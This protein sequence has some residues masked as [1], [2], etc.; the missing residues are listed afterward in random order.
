[1][2][3][4]FTLL[5]SLW[6]LSGSALA[7]FGDG[8]GILTFLFVVLG[9]L[10]ALVLHEFG[11]AYVAWRA[12]DHTVET[13]GYLSMDPLRYAD[14]VTSLVLPVI[15]LAIGGL[16]LPGG[17]VYLREDLMRSPAWRSAASLAGPAGTLL[18]LILLSLALLVGAGGGSESAL[19]P[20]VALLALFQAV[21]LAL[22]LLPVPGL[23]GY[24]VLRPFLPASFRKIM[25]P[26]ERFAIWILLAALFF[27]PGLSSVLFGAAFILTD[28]LGV[29]HE[30]ILKGF[31]AFQFWR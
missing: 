7:L 28:A 3:R 5:L 2:S 29:N 24:G 27:V 15:V 20:A 14:P 13:N 31:D 6:L 1:M 30:L 8:G 21:A 9:W 23:D 16:A 18:A 11:H 17:A 26:A 12:G 4:N 25:A 10:V 22:N 19:W